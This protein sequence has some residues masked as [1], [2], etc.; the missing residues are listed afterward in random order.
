MK[1]TAIVNPGS[2]IHSFFLEHHDR[3]R[4]EFALR[5]FLPYNYNARKRLRL[6]SNAAH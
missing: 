5:D 2:T 3:A 4:R 6:G 1:S